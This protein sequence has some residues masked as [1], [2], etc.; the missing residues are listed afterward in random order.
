[1]LVLTILPDADI[2]IEH[3]I[4]FLEHRGP[5]HSVI[6]M[7]V[8][9]MPFFWAYRSRAI[10]YFLA[11]VQH[12]AIGD[13]ITGRVQLFWPL[14]NRSYGLDIAIRSQTNVILEW[15]AFLAAVIIMIETRDII[16]FLQAHKSNLLLAIP[17]F[18]TLLPTLLSFPLEV[19]LWLVPP[20]V[21]Y[22]VI[23]SIAII[24]AVPKV[25]RAMHAHK[26]SG[27]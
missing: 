14:T 19:P 11:L 18:T 16:K 24:L 10:P 15:T 3:A 27:S 22:T 6:A 13:F 9:F 2:L 21:F 23:F 7:F 20:H 1:M 26:H 5:M 25:L 12:A 4:P 8:V 17:T